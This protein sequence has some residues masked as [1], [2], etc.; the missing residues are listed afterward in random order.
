M[1]A[2]GE[3]I[4]LNPPLPWLAVP[5][6]C[7]FV[8][9]IGDDRLMLS[10]LGAPPD[11]GPTTL[12]VALHDAAMLTL[13]GQLLPA[14][15][16]SYFFAPDDDASRTALLDLK[17]RLRKEQHITICQSAD[18]EASDRFTGFADVALTPV[19]L[20]ELDYA[21]LSTQSRF[22][23]RS[24]ALPLMISGMTGGTQRGGEINR[25]LARAAAM[26]DIPMGVGS[27]RVA[28][29]NPTLREMFDLKREFP[30][31]FLVGN[32]GCSQLLAGN[33]LERCRA[34]VDMIGADAL[35]IHVNVLQECI[36]TEGDRSFRGLFNA[37]ETINGKL[38][39]PLLIKEVGGGIDLATAKRLYQVGIRALDIGG[40]GGTSFAF[41]EGER[42][43]ASHGLAASFRDFGI[44]TAYSLKL[45]ADA[46]PDLQIVATGGVRDGL[47]V[48]KAVA[49]G[50]SMAGIGLPL[51]RAAI[52]SEE[53]PAALLGTYARGLKTAMLTTA[54]R[55][56]KELKGRISLGRHPL[57]Y[58]FQTSFDGRTKAP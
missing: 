32:I 19:A 39:V 24:F 35:A 2:K 58:P 38:A 11:G 17:L 52:D 55:T 7:G 27:Q 53:G 57:Q 15:D 36:Q 34:A 18:V 41:I 21:G 4:P 56:L 48:A 29:D 1:D 20:P 28:L 42:S 25:R 37:I 33:A 49:L 40:K 22:L 46:L 6:S 54:C 12:R 5:A 44:P 8:S 3:I 51:F 23:G 47:T 13:R 30:G 9:G 45:V 26:M 50:A 31:L 16:E 43:P 10:S 14:N